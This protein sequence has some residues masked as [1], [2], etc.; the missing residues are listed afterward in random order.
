MNQNLWQFVTMVDPFANKDDV[1]ELKELNE[2]DL[3]IIFKDGRRVIF[4]RYNGYHKNLVYNNI[5]EL[6]EEQEKKAFAYRLRTL[7]GRNR[8]TQ[9]ELAEAINVTPVMISKY[10]RGLSVPSIIV[11][12]KITKVLR[13]SL[14]DLFDKDY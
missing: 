6:S 1:V 14:D 13:C 3:L 4:D 2:W 9:E 7:M 8:I 12:R 5:N 10:V 11:A